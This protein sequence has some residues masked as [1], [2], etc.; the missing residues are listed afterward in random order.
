MA[1]T[2]TVN[3]IV[4][5]ELDARAAAAGEMIAV[6]DGE[7]TLSWAELRR[8]ARA[9][10]AALARQ[11]PPQQPVAVLAARRSETLILDYGILY[12]GCCCVPLEPE[13]PPHRL[14]RAAKDVGFDF[15][16]GCGSRPAFLPQDVRW[17]GCPAAAPQH[18]GEDE[19]FLLAERRRAVTPDSPLCLL[20]SGEDQ[21]MQWSHRDVQ[22]L[23]A[24]LAES[25]MLQPGDVIGSRAV[26]TDRSAAPDLF[27]SLYAGCRLEIL[28]ARLYS[29]PVELVRTL[30][31]KRVTIL[32]WPAQA[33]A[34]VS[35]PGTFHSVLPETLR[36]VFV[37]D[38]PLDPL[39]LERWCTAR[40]GLLF[41]ERFFRPDTAQEDP[42]PH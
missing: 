3:P 30:N 29:F 18:P 33:L 35:R 19:E 34:A 41:A 4:L 32:F 12:A 20:W 42:L 17:L 14:A 40:P 39:Q 8:R 6:S 9:F 5:D 25:T 27:G 28:P 24:G 37:T 13:S 21:K 7:L 16:V 38:E 31:E 23:L 11:C 22:R 15:A 10:G 26:F 36:A 2:G 1:Y